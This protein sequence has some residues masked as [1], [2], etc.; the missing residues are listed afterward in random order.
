MNSLLRQLQLLGLVASFSAPLHADILFIGLN[1]AAGEIRTARMVAEKR[2]E[3]FHYWPQIEKSRLAP[4]DAL[5]KEEMQIQQRVENSNTDEGLEKDQDRM[6]EVQAQRLAL[7]DALNVNETS[8]KAFVKQLEDQNVRLST[9]VISGHDGNG[10]FWGRYADNLT[11]DIFT[12]AFALAPHAA[13]TIR[14]VALLGCYTT[15]VGALDT[16][17]KKT[18]PNAHIF[19]GYDQKGPNSEV[20]SGHDYLKAFLERADKMAA[21]PTQEEFWKLFRQLPQVR[22][23]AASVVS[24]HFFANNDGGESLQELYDSCADLRIDSKLRASFNCYYQAQKGCENVP[25]DT[26]HGAVRLFY[27]ELQ[28]KAFCRGL[29]TVDSDHSLPTAELVL[30]LIFFENMRDN[31]I[32]LY[33]QHW[34]ELDNWLQS[35][36]VPKL[37]LAHQKRSRAELMTDIRRT[38]VAVENFGSAISPNQA[39]KDIFIRKFMAMERLEILDRTLLQLN[40][41]C[42][43]PEWVDPMQTNGSS[44]ARST[45]FLQN[46]AEQRWSTW[47]NQGR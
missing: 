7:R 22:Q 15:S 12:A 18:F 45:Q 23:L 35:M 11:S 44:C 6:V 3:G 30:R 29:M 19:G 20:A 46:I 34:I 21:T 24:S 13:S 8:L 37:N 10:M 41:G 38:R 2:G 28:D 42:L 4:I 32:R 27:E 26:A 31:L 25:K 5:A 1:P 14:T 40:T 47:R 36:G 43:P 39:S 33:G 9:V 17:W 16:Y